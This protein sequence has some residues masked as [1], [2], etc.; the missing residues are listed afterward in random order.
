[1]VGISN[2]H[3]DL[4]VLSNSEKVCQRFQ[5]CPRDLCEGGGPDGCGREGGVTE[6][7]RSAP[8]GQWAESHWTHTQAVCQCY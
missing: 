6:G 7:R 4:N 3:S 2:S 1:M 8:G 5:C